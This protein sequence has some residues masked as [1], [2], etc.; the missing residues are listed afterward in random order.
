MADWKGGTNGGNGQSRAR[1]P[2]SPQGDV[3]HMLSQRDSWPGSVRAMG[4]NRQL[5]RLVI[6]RGRGGN[7]S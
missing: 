5:H 7:C 6:G 1:H 3:A 4:Q 2:Q